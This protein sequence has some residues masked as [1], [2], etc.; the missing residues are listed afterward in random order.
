MLEREV[1]SGTATVTIAGRA[2][3]TAPSRAWSV[4][5]PRPLVFLRV[6]FTGDVQGVPQLFEGPASVQLGSSA[7]CHTVLFSRVDSHALTGRFNGGPPAPTGKAIAIE[8][9]VLNLDPATMWLDETLADG[10]RFRLTK[11]DSDSSMPIADVG[12]METHIGRVDRADGAA[13]DAGQGMAALDGWRLAMSFGTGGRV[14]LWRHHLVRSDG[15]DDGWRNLGG[16]WVEAWYDR[17]RIIDAHDRN[18]LAALLDLVLTRRRTDPASSGIDELAMNYA[19]E[20]NGTSPIEIRVASAGA[21]LELLAWDE[22]VEGETKGRRKDRIKQYNDAP[23]SQNLATLLDR[24]RI[25]TAD[26]PAA[27][28]DYASFDGSDPS[29]AVA[30]T[31]MRNRVMHPRR[32]D[33]ELSLPGHAWA[34]CSQLASHYL[35]LLVLRRLGYVG[36]YSDRFHSGFRGTTF[37]VAWAVPSTNAVG[38][39]Q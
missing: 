27:L 34:A 4:T 7:Y 6:D 31:A 12:V 11:A 33:G 16:P 37:P 29:G 13:F 23:A 1:W 39:D 15:H 19:I 10:W 32:R 24:A 21:G 3:F 28:D 22:L 30:V 26:Y 17:H 25:P 20:A 38:T 18:G 8:Y 9:R 36:R 2:P 5:T 35:E 14:G